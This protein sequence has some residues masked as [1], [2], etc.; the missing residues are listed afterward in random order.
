MKTEVTIVVPDRSESPEPLNPE[1]V[2]FIVAQCLNGQAEGALMVEG[3][4]STY[5]FNP[6]ALEEHRPMIQAMIDKLP[7]TFFPETGGGWSFLQMA[8]DRD[9]RQW[10]SE[11]RTMEGLVVLAIGIGKAKYLLPREFW[12]TLPGGVPYIQFEH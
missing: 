6:A 3:L 8:A 4:V 5:G 1:I 2:H 7:E 9:G 12:S 10:A 11:H